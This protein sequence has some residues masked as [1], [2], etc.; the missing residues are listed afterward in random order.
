MTFSPADPLSLTAFI[1][2]VAWIVVIAFFVIKR[3]V[4]TLVAIITTTLWC[5]LFT[6][7]DVSHALET[8][9]VPMFPLTMFLI[10]AGGIV[11]GLSPLLA[12]TPQFYSL[13]ALVLFQSFRFPLELVLHRWAQEKVIPET[14]TWT[15][16]NFDILAGLIS[17]LVGAYIVLKGPKLSLQKQRQW[18][19]IANIIGIVS[20]INV[21]RVIIMSSPLP[22]SWPVEPKLVLLAHFPYV[23]IGPICVSTAIAGH[24]ILTRAL[25]NS[26]I[27]RNSDIKLTKVQE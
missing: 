16:Q 18:A 12:N 21:L 17:L 8:H 22:F 2:I 25:W 6:W 5:G 3:N 4:S 11:F 9:A 20:L 19:W 10:A 24:V 13:G 1:A 27:K 26:D 15:G 23:F 7:I 14:M